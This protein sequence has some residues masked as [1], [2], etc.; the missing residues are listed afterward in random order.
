MIGFFG[1]LAGLGVLVF[2]AALGLNLVKKA[3]GTAGEKTKIGTGVWGVLICAAVLIYAQFAQNG[4][5]EYIGFIF[6]FALFSAAAGLTLLAIFGGILVGAT[7]ET[8]GKLTGHMFAFAVVAF[9][10]L[11]AAA[12]TFVPVNWYGVANTAAGLTP[13]F[14]LSLVDIVIWGGLI[15]GSIF[16]I[17]SGLRKLRGIASARKTFATGVGLLLLSG[18]ALLFTWILTILG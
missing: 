11:A 13:N 9:I 1:I 10:A 14:T 16:I 8:R 12:I 6:V 17:S 15:L 5:D 4:A 2:T 7:R 3:A 18:F